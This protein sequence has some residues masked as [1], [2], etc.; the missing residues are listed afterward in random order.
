MYWFCYV[1]RMVFFFSAYEAPFPVS[2]LDAV[3]DALGRSFYFILLVVTHIKITV[4]AAVFTENEYYLFLA[5]P[6][7]IRT[8]WPI[9]ECVQR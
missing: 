4:R 6:Q 5:K 8:S 7:P 3:D 9:N 1:V 2:I